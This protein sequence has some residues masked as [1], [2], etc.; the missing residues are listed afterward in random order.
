MPTWYE[1][2][3]AGAPNWQCDNYNLK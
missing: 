1:L 2:G 3:A